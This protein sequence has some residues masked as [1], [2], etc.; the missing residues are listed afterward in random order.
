MMTL[1]DLVLANDYAALA[2][3]EQAGP[4]A[5]DALVPLLAHADPLVRQFA[6]ECL[7][8]AGGPRAALALARALTDPALG[9]SA[10]AVVGL[11][12]CATPDVVPELVLAWDRVSDWMVRVRL[13]KLLGT[14]DGW[15]P[16]LLRE[17]V[18][19][20]PHPAVREAMIVAL[21][22][23]G[24]P[25]ARVTFA[26]L[27]ADSEPVDRPRL[28][29]HAQ[30][31]GQPWLLKPLLPLLD[32]WTPA[33]RLVEGAPGPSHLRVCDLTV[34]LVA[35]LA[36]RTFNGAPRRLTNYDLAVMDE[37]RAFLEALPE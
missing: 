29:E 4:A 37:V 5:A 21:S 26:R 13:A 36:K 20:E 10:A 7:G 12:R 15:D 14:L 30:Y 22:R 2:R 17:R 16:A 34:D 1:A 6:A 32:D 8:M 24:E 3:S 11:A 28:L 33:L 25:E 19:T 31:I 27:L 35:T 23:R 18:G 9:V